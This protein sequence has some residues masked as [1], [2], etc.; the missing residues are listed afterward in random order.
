MK[1]DIP[2]DDFE[3]ALCAYQGDDYATAFNLFSSL[4]KHGDR[5]VILYLGYLYSRG[6]GTKKDLDIADKL[7]RELEKSGDVLGIYYLASLLLENG[8]VE[9]AKTRFEVAANLKHASAAYWAYELNSGYRGALINCAKADDFLALAAELGHI[10]AKRDLAKRAM[11]D[12]QGGINWL[13]AFLHYCW[14]K[15]TGLC[16]IILHPND[17]R[18]R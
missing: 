15:Y 4:E 8:D 12:A 6:L 17:Q 11:L 7:F 5:R 1:P 13:R 3:K 14:I 10:Y 2:K 18:G 16:H 9:A